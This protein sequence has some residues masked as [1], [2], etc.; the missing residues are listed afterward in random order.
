YWGRHLRETV[1]FG[2]GIE[3]L[4]KESERVLIEVGAGQSLS[5]VIRLH[6]EYQ[7][8]GGER[9]V[10]PTLRNEFDA[11]PD[12]AFLLTSL[13]KLWL[14]GIHIDWKQLYHDEQRS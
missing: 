11:Q 1:Q 13:A 3:Q 12:Q 4:L 7:G 9:L 6:P 10:A 2:R 14:N 5:S 8:Q